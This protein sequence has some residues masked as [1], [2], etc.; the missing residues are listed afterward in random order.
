MATLD[1]TAKLSVR[2]L[3]IATYNALKSEHRATINGT[4]YAYVNGAWCIVRLD[5]SS[6]V[7]FAQ[8][9][10]TVASGT[11]ADRRRARKLLAV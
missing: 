10:P 9:R 2:S 8:L 4:R 1:T 6:T 11:R 3:E 7:Q 5:K